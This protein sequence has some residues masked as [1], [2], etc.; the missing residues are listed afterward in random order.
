MM[1]RATAWG[2]LAMA[3]VALSA[4][5][6]A[7]PPAPAR[8]L[9]EAYREALAASE[10]IGIDEQAIVQA[11]QL[12]ARTLGASLPAVTFRTLSAWVGG[13]PGQFATG[14]MSQTDVGFRVSQVNL[15]F[16]R[17]LA[18]VRQAKSGVG[19]QR[20]NL[21][22]AKQL[23]LVS[24][25]GAF[26]GELQA[27][28][29]VAA[30][31]RL[32]EFAAKRLDKLHEWVRV[33]RSREA[34]AL[35]QDEQISTLESQQ[36]ESARQS[37]ADADLLAFLTRSPVEPATL[38]TPIAAEPR[39]LSDYLARVESRPDVEAARWS[40]DFAQAGVR[41]AR[42]DRFPQLSYLADSYQS[43][44]GSK[45]DSRWD[46]QLTLS[47][48][49]F[50]WGA[51]KAEEGQARAAAAAADL[52]LQQA[53]R[54]AELDIRN[55]YRNYVSSRRQLDIE[56][57]A[58]ALAE[59]D[60]DLQRQDETRG[61]V[62]AIDVLQSLDRLNSARLAYTNALLNARLAA[63]ELEVSAGARPEDMDLR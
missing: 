47:L 36:E 26:Y 20:Q 57:R 59:R 13:G 23:L 12:Y 38:D 35:A 25:A 31:I 40:A 15:S 48:P 39:P 44:P 53:R 55:S 63:I 60:F 19:V 1:A 56:K 37:A 11:E 51:L 22:R 46:A 34:D 61:L 30:S 49:L 29:N 58:V 42:G 8:S 6:R 54:S 50:S 33:G 27:Q 4:P 32:R 41:V 28:E 62:T 2:W 52:A 17:E 14:P 45:M 5:A 9:G 7:Q 18:A 21:L 16:Y 43:R 10:S 24:L 3:A